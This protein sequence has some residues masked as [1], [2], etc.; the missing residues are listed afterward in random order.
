[1]NPKETISIPQLEFLIEVQ[2]NA[3][4]EHNDQQKGVRK[5]INT[6]YNYVSLKITTALIYGYWQREV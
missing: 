5:R 1:M 2:V 3:L 6:R 4:W